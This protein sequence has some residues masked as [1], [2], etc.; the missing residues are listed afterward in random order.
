MITRSE[1]ALIDAEVKDSLLKALDYIKTNCADHDYVLFLAEGE[2]KERYVK[3]ASKLNPYTIDNREDRY[4]DE[5]R[6]D[7]FIKFMRTFY[8]F[9]KGKARTVD[10]DYI[11]TME[12]MIYTHIWESKPFLKQLFRLATLAN[13]ESYHWS[14]QVPDMTKHEFIRFRIRDVIK[15]KGLHLGSVISKGYHSSLRNAFAHSEYH[16]DKYN[17]LIHL[18][19]YKGGMWDIP[20]LSYDDWSRRFA[21]TALLSYHLYNEKVYKRRS[22]VSDFGTNE[23]LIIHPVNR[24][25]CWLRKIYYDEKYD[26]FAFYR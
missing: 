11:R 6:Q 17:K 24:L 5:T 3:T 13:M 1:F 21:Y 8:S 2:Y 16:F 20:N 18:D 10:N 14:V 9:P 15:S 4:D 25:K 23:F 19:T 7:F 26:R 22:L 12:L